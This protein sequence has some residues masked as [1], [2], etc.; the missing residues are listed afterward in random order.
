AIFAEKPRAILVSAQLLV[1]GF[2]DPS[3]NAVVMTYPSS[4]LIQVMQAA[5][6]CVRSAPGKKHAFVMQARND[7]LA[8][9]FDHRWLY[10][11]ISDELRPALV[12]I[13]YGSLIEL[14]ERLAG[15]LDAHRVPVWN[16]DQVLHAANALSPGATCRVLLSG[17]PFFGDRTDFEN[18]S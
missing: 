5:G 18:E 8:Y 14:S 12:D 16:R 4:S 7:S 10:Q 2:D 13:S 6:R 3:I 15:L 11:E 1:E 17:L 9:Y